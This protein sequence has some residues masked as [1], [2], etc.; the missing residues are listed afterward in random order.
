AIAKEPADRYA[1]GEA[2]AEDLRRFLADRPIR[3]RRVP[4]HERAWRWCRRNPVVAGLLASVVLLLVCLAVGASV[5][6]LSLKSAL[7]AS[8]AERTRAET[9]E[10]GGKEKLWQAYLAR[11]RAGRRSRQVGQRYESLAAIENA[12]PLARE[13]D[14]PTDRFDD[15]R[16]EAIA[17]LALPD[18]R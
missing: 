4:G 14:L 17:C 3:A 10:R 6:A 11:A 8:E 16:N 13:L 1:T 2:L 12:V 18:L 15:M 7:T 9:A 5:A